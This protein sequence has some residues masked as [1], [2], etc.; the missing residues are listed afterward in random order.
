MDKAG[1]AYWE[2]V[3]D[4]SGLPSPV[5]PQK[6]GLNNYVN[7]E[8]HLLFQRLLSGSDEMPRRLVEVGC[9]RSVWLPYF[10]GTLGLQVAGLDYSPEG[11]EQ[12][13]EI[14]ARAGVK[15]EIACS[16][17]FDPPSAFRGSFDIVVSFG[18]AEHFERTAEC[19]RA[20]SALAKPGGLV[21][22]VIPNMVGLVGLLQKLADRKVYDIHVPL[23]RERLSTAHSEAGLSVERC[24]YFLPANFGVVNL[25][26]W[27]SRFRYRI[28]CKVR[29]AASTAVWAVD[30][31]IP[32]PS[33]RITSPYIVAVARK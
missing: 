19:V 24:F 12:S 20:L 16:D 13:R 9:A 26:G 5:D 29:S 28:A 27:S 33:N 30:R 17:L 23:S 10:A 18:V 14:L 11:C 8:F 31:L 4:V 21:L 7:R 32:I 2:K 6:R 22:T 15:G 25:E 1:K 3:W